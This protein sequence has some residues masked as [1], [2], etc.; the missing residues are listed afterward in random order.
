MDSFPSLEDT[1]LSDN[2]EVDYLSAYGNQPLEPLFPTDDLSPSFSLFDS[3]PELVPVKP[4]PT[5]SED[6]QFSDSQSSPSQ[7]PVLKKPRISPLPSSTRTPR[8]K[9]EDQKYN[10]RLE[11]NKK[12]A[13]ASRE[14][15]KVLK[16]EL[17]EQVSGLTKENENL[18][19]EITELNTENRV[20]KQE[21]VHLNNM[22]NSSPYLAKLMAQYEYAQANYKKLLD[23]YEPVKGVPVGNTPEA[24]A[25][26]L[27]IVLHS[28][29][30]HFTNAPAT[31]N[32]LLKSGNISFMPTSMAS[33]V[34]VL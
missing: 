34:E 23:T 11:A 14:R 30:Q 7:E 27:L 21:F 22:V 26:M 18:E 19:T 28:F 16:T 4:E 24:A 3:L 17:E 15:K 12:S 13:Q 10:K 8:R 2:M 29:S 9:K 1:F 6:L 5:D 32:A 33:T 20:L 31:F 25:A